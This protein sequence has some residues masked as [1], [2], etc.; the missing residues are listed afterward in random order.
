M[1]IGN[2]FGVTMTAREMAVAATDGDGAMNYDDPKGSGYASI[3]AETQSN[4]TSVMLLTDEIL[5]SMP[6]IRCTSDSRLLEGQSS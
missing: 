5:L 3:A 2:L 6:T 4:F 1:G